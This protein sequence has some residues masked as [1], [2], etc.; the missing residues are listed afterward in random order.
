MDARLAS[1]AWRVLH[2]GVYCAASTPAGASL[3]GVAARLYYGEGAHFSHYTAARLHGIDTRPPIPLVW[4]TVPVHISKRRRPGVDRTRSTQVGAHAESVRGQPALTV[5]RTMVDL[6]AV[7]DEA[8]WLF[9][10]YDVVRR[11]QATPEAVLAAA[12]GLRPRRGTALVGR[13]LDR[14][15]PDFDSGLEA[16]AAEHLRR[17]GFWLQPQLEVWDGMLLLARL[18]FGDEKLR[19]GVEVDGDRYHS[20]KEARTRD[21]HRD[22]RRR[23]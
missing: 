8:T 19:V 4:L 6:A 5:A 7:L 11:G 18:D 1:G 12:E 13:C 10:L 22:L 23:G 17:A 21:L 3:R 14:F 15:H 9:R 20:S 16:D 2:P